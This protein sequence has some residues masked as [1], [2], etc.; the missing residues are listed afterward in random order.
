MTDLLIFIAQ[1]KGGDNRIHY[2]PLKYSAHFDCSLKDGWQNSTVV[3]SLE[4]ID[5]F[6]LFLRYFRV[7]FDWNNMSIYAVNFFLCR[8]RH[9]F[10]MSMTCRHNCMSM[11]ALCKTRICKGHHI[12]SQSG[13]KF[14]RK[15]IKQNTQ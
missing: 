4:K 10:L 1:R 11:T 5:I 2:K 9:V 14:S 15:H 3:V 13:I 8:H 7:P 6:L 12:H